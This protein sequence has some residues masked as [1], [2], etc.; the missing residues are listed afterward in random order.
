[1]PEFL[2]TNFSRSLTRAEE[3]IAGKLKRK[4]LPIISRFELFHAVWEM[5]EYAQNQKLYL[6]GSLPSEDDFRRIRRGLLAGGIISN[7]P[8]YGSS[9]LRVL[10]VSDM[11]ADNIV[12]LADTTCYISHISAMQR[13]GL[14]NRMP[15][16]LHITRPDRSKAKD[17]LSQKMEQICSDG[18]VNPFKLSYINHPGKVRGRSLTVSSSKIFGRYLR[19]RDDNV[20]LSTIGQTFIDTIDK[21]N[22]CGGMAHVLDVWKEYAPQYLQKIIETV[23][24]D[25]R[26]IIKCRAGYI[27]EE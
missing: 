6:R 13:W 1:M 17:L 5:Y 8:D 27:V 12:C 25:E 9:V 16:A 24:L 2:A 10:T 21:P 7:D 20:R 4:N 19:T 3:Y 15:K 18:E 23:D 26:P 22:L 14:T 11:P